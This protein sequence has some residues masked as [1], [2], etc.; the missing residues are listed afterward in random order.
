[1]EHSPQAPEARAGKR[2][3]LSVGE[4]T[5]M[6]THEQADTLMMAFAALL[7]LTILVYIAANGDP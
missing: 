5:L 1:M 3:A 6:L 2:D 4:E 7:A